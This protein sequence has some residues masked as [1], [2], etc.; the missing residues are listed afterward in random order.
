MF[1]LVSD[2]S[3]DFTK[4]EAEKHNINLIPFY[5]SLDG[6]NFLK[7]G[8]DITLDEFFTKLQNDKTL[9]PKTS[10]PSPQ[11]YIDTFKPILD[12]GEDILAITISSKLSGSNQSAINAVEILKDDYP[13]RKILILDSLNVSVGC[14]LIVRELIKMRD[15]N[16]GIEESFNLA[17]KVREKTKTYFTIDTLEYLKKGGRIGPA[18]ALVGGLLNLRPILHIQ[19]GVVSPLEKVRGKKNAVK[20]MKETIVKALKDS[21]NISN[22]AA[23]HINELE[24]AKTFRQDIEKELNIKIETPISQIGATIGAHVG[25]GA[26]AFSY[27]EK[28]ESLKV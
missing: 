14:G 1:T 25:P 17:T 18:A 21:G 20:L 3:C 26:L 12:K 11:D 24:E 10:Q 6:E 4:E 16:L 28:Y 19:D 8:K 5:I 7:E 22:M 23:G 15:V 9:Y 13:D 27:C 2:N